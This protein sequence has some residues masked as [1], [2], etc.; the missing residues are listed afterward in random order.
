[1][2]QNKPKN[3]LETP[4]PF[5][6]W[7]GGKRQLLNELHTR[8][9]QAGDFGRYHEPFL[10]GGALYYALHRAEKIKRQAYLSDYNPRLINTYQGVKE[11][12]KSVIRHLHKHKKQ[13]TE[14]YYYQVREQLRDDVSNNTKIPNS[15]HAA[16]IIY[17]NKTGYNGLY[18]E[19]SKGLYNV[20]FGRYKK[21]MIC[22]EENLRACAKAL[23]KTKLKAQH[24]QEITKI[25]QPGDLVYFDPPYDPISKTAAFTSYAKGGFGEDSQRLL[26][27]TYKNLH[28]KGVKVMLSNSYT[29]FIRELYADFTIKAVTANRNI[30]SNAKKRGA[31]SEAL[32]QNF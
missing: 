26:A 25:A 15:K 14:T 1:M 3:N 20:P 9:D 8:I 6:K 7:V 10:G 21:P 4:R 19:N 16:R 29:D 32:V 24:F 17:L 23:K 12:V 2:T 30:N 18:R 11:D 27:Q 5:L 13:H 31:I 22:D 28:A